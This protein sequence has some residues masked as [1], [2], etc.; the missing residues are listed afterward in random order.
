MA[1]WSVTQLIAEVQKRTENRAANKMDLRMEF[2]LALDQLCNEQHF[3]WRKRRGQFSSVVGQTTP[4]DISI[5]NPDFAELDEAI[6]MNAD[7]VTVEKQLQHITDSGQQL[8]MLLN[9]VQDTPA[10]I[11]VDTETSYQN[12]YF[13]APANVAQLIVFFY[14]AMPMITDITKDNIPLLP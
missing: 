14:W 4:Y 11:F 5:N 8:Q 1:V 9:N 12:F 7:G 10:C 2:F 6:L 3:W 13:Q